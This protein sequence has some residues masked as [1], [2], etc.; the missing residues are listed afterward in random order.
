MTT[1]RD[2]KGYSELNADDKKRADAAEAAVKLLQQHYAHVIVAA[3]KEE[4]NS[5][6]FV[7]MRV[8]KDNRND[9]VATLAALVAEIVDGGMR[10]LDEENIPQASYDFFIGLAKVIAARNPE[11]V[12][13]FANVSSAAV[14]AVKRLVEREKKKGNDVEVKGR[15]MNRAQIESLCRILGVDPNNLDHDIPV[16]IR[17]NSD[18]LRNLSRSQRRDLARL[19][20]ID[21]KHL[22]PKEERDD[23]E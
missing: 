16:P 4:N 12:D 20:N 5:H 3:A 11:K 9:T 21:I 10:S 15:H 17:L 23:E 8:G 14:R 22:T 6:G 7:G 18:R 19:L 1:Y 2:D 13:D